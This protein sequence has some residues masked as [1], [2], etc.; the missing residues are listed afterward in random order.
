[1][2]E[3]KRGTIACVKMQGGQKVTKYK[4]EFQISKH[5]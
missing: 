1:V 2:E 4:K 3:S 5:V